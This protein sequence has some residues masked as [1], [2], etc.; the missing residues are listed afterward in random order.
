MNGGIGGSG[1]GIAQ[2]DIIAELPPVSTAASSISASGAVN[3]LGAS[4]NGGANG[5]G[6]APTASFDTTGFTITTRPI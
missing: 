6:N 3:I 4:G 2:I 5:I 1:T